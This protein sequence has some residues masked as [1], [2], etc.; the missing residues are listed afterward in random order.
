MIGAIP[1]LHGDLVIHSAATIPCCQDHG[2]RSFYQEREAGHL[3]KVAEERVS[4][5]RCRAL[6]GD[7]LGWCQRLGQVCVIHRKFRL[8]GASPYRC[9]VRALTFQI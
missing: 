6:H 5:L 7:Q 4:F 2:E 3:R 1:V 9:F 8:V